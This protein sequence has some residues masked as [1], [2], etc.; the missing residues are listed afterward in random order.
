MVPPLDGE[1][2]GSRCDAPSP[3]SNS[4][5]CSSIKCKA[6]KEAVAIATSGITPDSCPSLQ[7]LP[8]CCCETEE[9]REHVTL[10]SIIVQS[11]RIEG[12]GTRT[13]REVSADARARAYGKKGE[14]RHG[15][16]AR[17]AELIP[18]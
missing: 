14:T 15:T 17:K 4:S 8:S 6:P 10:S 11:N 1:T 3:R 13:D 16:D 5:S 7:E 2:C 12:S 18:Q 9:Q